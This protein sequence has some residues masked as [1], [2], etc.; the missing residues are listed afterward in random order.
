[1]EIWSERLVIF[2]DYYLVLV[3]K[4]ILLVFLRWNVGH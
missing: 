3:S 1:M 2:C 4:N